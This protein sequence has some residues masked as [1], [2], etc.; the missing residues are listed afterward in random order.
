MRLKNM[1]QAGLMDC[2]VALEKAGGDMDKA[3]ALLREMGKAKAKKSEARVAAEG[4]VDSYIH[5]GGRIGVLLEVNCETDFAAKSENFIELMKNISMHIA[6]SSPQY[7]DEA[8]VPTAQ[9]EAEKEILRN[10]AV[11][12]G[13]PATVIEK[14][15][16]GQVKKFYGD[17]CLMCQEYIREPG[18]TVRDY[19]MEVAGVIGEKISVRRFIRWEMGEGIEKK[20][21]DFASEVAKTMEAK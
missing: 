15:L 14:M 5:G 9:L 10:K 4:R 2:K 8:S 3:V 13:K 17:V 11:A 16:D 6:A 7:L 19:V 21:E 18:K 1:T 12:E 20:S